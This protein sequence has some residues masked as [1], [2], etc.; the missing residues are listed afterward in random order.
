MVSGRAIV[1]SQWY[2]H[3]AIPEHGAEL[4]RTMIRSAHDMN[5]INGRTI[6]VPDCFRIAVARRNILNAVRLMIA[7]SNINGIAKD[8]L[9]ATEVS[10]NMHTPDNGSYTV[11]SADSLETTFPRFQR[12]WTYCR[13]P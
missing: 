3:H 6:S 4:L 1:L 2:A 10:G 11:L 8:P 9:G 5:K 13:M 7:T 12:E